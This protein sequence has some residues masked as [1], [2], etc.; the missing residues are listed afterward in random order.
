MANEGSV[1]GTTKGWGEDNLIQDHHK[2]VKTNKR[3]VAIIE[4]ILKACY[5]MLFNVHTLFIHTDVQIHLQGSTKPLMIFA[6]CTHED[7]LNTK[8]IEV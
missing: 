4:I 3:N 5:R 2:F 1:G 8:D 6:L 7:N